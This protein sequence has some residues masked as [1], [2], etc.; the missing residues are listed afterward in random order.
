VPDTV[1]RRTEEAYVHWIRRFIVF[2]GKRNPREL[3]SAEVSAFVTWLA[4]EL[5]GH[6]DVS[7]TIIYTHV[8]N[9]GGLSV[10]SPID[11]W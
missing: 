11:R 10:K 1:G 4:V 3:G 5:L 9:R 2:H 7:T 8:L 6:A